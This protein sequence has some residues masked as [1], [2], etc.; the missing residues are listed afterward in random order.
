VGRVDMDKKRLWIVAN[1]K[2]NKNLKEALDWVSEVGSKIEKKENVRVVVCPPFV[3]VGEVAHTVKVGN[4]PLEV[5]VQDLSPFDVGAYTGEEAAKLVKDFAS[6]AI[7]GHSERRK[8]FGET[9]VLIEEKIKQALLNNITPLLCVQDENTPIPQECNLIAYEPIFAIGSG[10]PDSPEG[11]NA[12]SAKI[13]EV[14]G[15]DV[16][17]LYGGSVKSENVKNFLE[18]DLISGVL[19]GGAS[20]DAQEFIKIVEISQTV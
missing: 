6:I 19:I 18:Q 9:D 11:A 8:S 16:E 17:V 2:S 12:I 5:G 14:H 15:T 1:W 10:K 3:D 7:L 20:L 13:K 4:F